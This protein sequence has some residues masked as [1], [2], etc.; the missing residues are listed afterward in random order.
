M[1]RGLWNDGG[2]LSC[3]LEGQRH[4]GSI[5]VPGWGGGGPRA[6]RGSGQL[7]VHRRS[8]LCNG[9]LSCPLVAAPCLSVC[10]LIIPQPLL[11]PPGPRTGQPGV[12][13]PR[14]AALAWHCPAVRAGRVRP[15]QALSGA[16]VRPAVR[17]DPGEGAQAAGCWP[18]PSQR[19]DSCA[20][21]GARAAGAARGPHSAPR[22]EGSCS[23]LGR[24]PQCSALLA[25]QPLLSVPF[26]GP[27]LP[28][29][30]EPNDESGANVDAS[31]MWRDDREQFCRVAKQIVQKSL[32]L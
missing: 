1:R 7:A 11:A 5:G 2:V 9:R 20:R 26:W 6:T 10:L 30:S 32:G 27:R 17:R 3:R 21:W 31:K 19:G 24:V 22:A 18:A 28:S 4:R 13:C 29:L 8:H 15:E 23:F 12:V 16:A 14:G 25:A